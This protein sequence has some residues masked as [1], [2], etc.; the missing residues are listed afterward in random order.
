[1]DFIYDEEEN[2]Q[3]E[4]FTLKKNIK[5]PDLV[6]KTQV[7]VFLNHNDRIA[8]QKKIEEKVVEQQKEREN[9]I[10]E[11]RKNFLS[12]KSNDDSKHSHKKGYS[13]F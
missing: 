6:N 2:S 4:V 12:H 3:H 11:N 13:Y 9:L 5:N 7:P 1:M 10:L 8:L